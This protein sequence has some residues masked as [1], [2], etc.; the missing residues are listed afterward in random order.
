[1]HPLK[2]AELSKKTLRDCF[3]TDAVSE[4]GGCLDIELEFKHSERKA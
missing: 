2:R 3:D 4:V 1:M